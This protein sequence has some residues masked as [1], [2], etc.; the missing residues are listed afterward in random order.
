MPSRLDSLSSLLECPACRATAWSSAG[1][2]SSGTLTCTVCGASY[3]SARGVLD[4]GDVDQDPHVRDERAAVRDTERRADLGGI[5]DTFDDLADAQGDLRDALLALPHGNASRYYE[6]PGYFANVR[7]SAPIFDFLAT[8]LDLQPGHRLLDLGAD[9]T[10]ST[11]HFARRGLDCTAVDIN[12]HLTVGQ[13]YGAHY[14]APYHLVRADMRRVPFKAATFDIVFAISALHHNPELS[15]IAATIARVLKPGGQLA[16]SEPYCTSEDAKRAFGQAQIAAGISEQTYLLSEWHDAFAAVGL[17][18]ETLRVCESFCAVYRK[19]TDPSDIVPTGTAGLFRHAYAGRLT[20]AHE[21]PATIAA[22]SDWTIP[23]AIENASRAVWCSTSQFP[24][25]VCYHLHRRT[26]EGL[27]LVSYD[28]LRTLLPRAIDPGSQ[29]V[30][31]L[32][33]SAIETPGDYVVEIDLV[34]EY[35]SWFAPHH[36]TGAT[37]AFRVT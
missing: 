24:V 6:E 3:T 21:P 16:L 33:V 10:W 26:D 32:R 4:L 37:V 14:G 30:V 20:V 23:V 9:L 12:H 7:A 1:S 15:A 27:R 25:H 22:G 8:H 19:R 34:H 18:V 36:F 17:D 31:P 5:N 13:M 29:A 11:S 2:E 35:V 28:N